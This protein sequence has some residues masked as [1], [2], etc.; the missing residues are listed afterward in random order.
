MSEHKAELNIIGQVMNA[1]L[2][3]RGSNDSLSRRNIRQV[4]FSNNEGKTTVSIDIFFS[5]IDLVSGGG[6]VEM[7]WRPLWTFD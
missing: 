7:R 5:P 1:I 3:G 6:G 2:S 4:R